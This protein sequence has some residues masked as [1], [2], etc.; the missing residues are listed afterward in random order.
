M[1]KPCLFCRR[2]AELTAGS[3]FYDWEELFNAWS[4]TNR[5]ISDWRARFEGVRGRLKWAALDETDYGACPAC[6]LQWAIDNEGYAERYPNHLPLSDQ[7]RRWT[8][9]ELRALFDKEG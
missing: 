7:Y 8:D 6:A 1:A 9:V 4:T 5:I 3:R 2:P